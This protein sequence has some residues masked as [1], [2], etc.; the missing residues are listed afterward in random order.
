MFIVVLKYSDLNNLVEAIKF[1][2][3]GM[4]RSSRIE[5]I[6]LQQFYCNLLHLYTDK[7]FTI[8][9]SDPLNPSSIIHVKFSWPIQSHFSQYVSNDALGWHHYCLCMA[10]TPHTLTPG[11][12]W[13]PSA[14]HSVVAP[15]VVSQPLAS[16]ALEPDSLQT[17]DQPLSS[18]LCTLYTP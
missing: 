12:K 6:V 5:V 1:M 18:V 11:D 15:L 8:N 7:T 2:Y 4:E 16:R 17:A 3:F 13:Q 14:P 10:L 9:W